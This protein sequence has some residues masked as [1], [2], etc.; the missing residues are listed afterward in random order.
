MEVRA[1]LRRC[2]PNRRTNRLV[3]R[4]AAIESAAPLTRILTVT[5][6]YDFAERVFTLPEVT[7]PLIAAVNVPNAAGRKGKGSSIAFLGMPNGKK[8]A[9]SLSGRGRPV[10]P[11][12]IY[13]AAAASLTD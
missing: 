6:F 13:S 1:V 8:T 3:A 4:G 12:G 11:E 5:A 10:V 7:S 9:P 2:V